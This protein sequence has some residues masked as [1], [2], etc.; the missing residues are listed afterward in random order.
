ME[1]KETIFVDGMIFKKPR[2]GA[3]TFVKGAVS[4]NVKNFANFLKKYEHKEWLNIDLKQ[5]REGKLYLQLNT[6]EKKV[7]KPNDDIIL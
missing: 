6:Y 7:E 3:P 2:E 5:S 1:Q 4:I